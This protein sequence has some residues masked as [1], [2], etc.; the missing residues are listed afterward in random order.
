MD[1]VGAVSGDFFDAKHVRHLVDHAHV[2]RRRRDHHG[3]VNAAQA[4]AAH[5][6]LVHRQFL[7]RALDQRHFDLLRG[8]H[9]SISGN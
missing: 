8:R 3:L 6:V 1:P 4:D 9:G 5:I 2:L 7:E